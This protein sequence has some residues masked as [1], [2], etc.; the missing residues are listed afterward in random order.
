MIFPNFLVI[1]AAKAGTTSL[2]YYLKQHPQIFMSSWKEPKFFSLEGEKLDFKGPTQTINRNSINNLD[3]YLELFKDVR[4]ETAIGEASPVY[5]YCPKAPVKIKQ[6]IP[7][8]KLIVVLRH[9]ADRAFSSFAHL[10]RA[11]YET[12][13]FEQALEEE[14]QRIKEKWAPL[15][16]Y[17]EKGFYARQLKRYFELFDR[18]QIKIYLYEE[19]QADSVALVQ[20]AYKFLGVDDKFVPDLTRLNVSGVPKNRLIHNL[21]TRDNQL[22]TLVKNILP[23]SFRKNIARDLKKKNLGAK[24]KISSE[25]RNNLTEFYR[26]EI[27]ELETTIDRD[28]SHWL[29][30]T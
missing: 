2:F 1:G 10:I 14:P 27:L 26:E 28:L 15:W 18:E 23:T 5:L 11:G 12:L 7:N 8:A 6:Y 24:P 13:T 9:P 29:V 19:L 21:L 22:K 16:Y 17:K 25:T 30:T 20:D 3:S 4:E